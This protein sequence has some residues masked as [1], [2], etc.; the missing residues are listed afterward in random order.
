MQRKNA[1][2]SCLAIILAL[3]TSLCHAQP[4]YYSNPL[5]FDNDGKA[6]FTV[7]RPGNGGPDYGNWYVYP[8]SGSCPP[9]M[10]PYA[11]GCVTQWGLPGDYPVQGDYDAL[12][13]RHDYAIVRPS[14][15]YWYLKYSAFSGTFTLQ[16]G[17]PGDV[18]ASSDLDSDYHTDIML[19]RPSNEN[20]YVRNSSTGTT[21]ILQMMNLGMSN[22]RALPDFYAGG[23]SYH[24]PTNPPAIGS[25]KRAIVG[26]LDCGTS[27]AR[28]K[29]YVKIDY[30]G[31]Q[32]YQGER[33]G[34]CGTLKAASGNYDGD[35][36]GRVEIATWQS[37]TGIWKLYSIPGQTGYPE[38]TWGVSGDVPFMADFNGDGR[39]DLTVW[40]PSNGTFYVLPSNN[41]CPPHAIPL[42]PGPGCYRQWGVAGDVPVRK[43]Y[44]N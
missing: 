8:S 26:E 9:Q 28:L 6:D 16:F 36:N 3:S 25:M 40:R 11:G 20:F 22:I 18:P 2:L 10:T 38:V 44:F 34:P 4:F 27:I 29:W 5:D 24:P 19:Y 7:W 39:A 23:N 41:N 1:F 30:A 21:S 17:L 33:L 42:N 31:V 13:G 35:I 15:W 12:D 43:G 32:F 14:T 37:T